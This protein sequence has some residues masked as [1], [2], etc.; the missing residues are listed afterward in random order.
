[1]KNYSLY[2]LLLCFSFIG[3]QKDIGEN[4]TDLTA[5]KDKDCVLYIPFMGE[6]KYDT[7]I[8]PLDNGGKKYLINQGRIIKV[9]NKFNRPVRWEYWDLLKYNLDREWDFYYT[10]NQISSYKTAKYWYSLYGELT[11]DRIDYKVVRDKDKL[12]HI[13]RK[14]SG[15]RD[16]TTIEDTVSLTYYPDNSIKSY[17]MYAGAYASQSETFINNDK[18]YFAKDIE[19]LEL[20]FLTGLEYRPYYLPT[21]KDISSS[22]YY[23]AQTTEPYTHFIRYIDKEYNEAGYPIFYRE[24]VEIHELVDEYTMTYEKT[25]AYRKVVVK[26]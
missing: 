16:S 20:A 12:K 24:E 23:N 4:D 6:P 18:N 14:Y 5:K 9:Y 15:S 7:V 11:I 2:L 25:I 17:R 21:H 1:M 10:N 8:V 19:E 13:Y 3:C 26:K 22:V